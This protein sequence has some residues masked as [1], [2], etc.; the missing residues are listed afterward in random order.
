M[1]REHRHV[2]L[3]LRAPVHV[4]SPDGP[5]DAAA[6]P[7]LAKTPDEVCKLFFAG[8]VD[9]VSSGLLRLRPEAHVQRRL[10]A[11]AEAP[12]ACQLVGGKAKVEEDAVHG[13][14]ATLAADGIDVTKV[15]VHQRHAVAEAL[16]APAGAGVSR[17]AGG[18][19]AAGR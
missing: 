9:P 7:L 4:T 18:L 16:Q 5:G 14:E 8:L 2:Q 15:A 11:E 10:G 13:R 19:A 6:L 17:A 12:R 1:R 3:A